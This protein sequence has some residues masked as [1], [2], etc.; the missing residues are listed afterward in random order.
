MSATGT[1]KLGKVPDSHWG[2]VF[3]YV[4][5]LTWV[6]NRM[7]GASGPIE[8]LNLSPR[9]HRLLRRV[10][11]RTVADLVAKWPDAIARVHGVG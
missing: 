2:R 6:D 7:G 4:A 8:A 9:G 3:Y 5:S 1:F 10:G 11:C